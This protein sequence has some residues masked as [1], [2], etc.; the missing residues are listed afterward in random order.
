M[1][2][3]SHFHRQPA[4]IALWR[5]LFGPLLRWL[6]SGR[7]RV[8]LSLGA[9]V[10][11]FSNPL[12]EFHRAR[13]WLEFAPDTVGKILAIAT[14]ILLVLACYHVAR[15]FAALPP[16][17]RR[18]PQLC[19]HACFWLWMIMAWNVTPASVTVRTVLAGC[20]LFLPL[21]LWR[22]GYLL[23]TAQRGKMAG[24]SLHDHWFY[25]WPV[26]GGGASAAPYGKGY[27]Y[28]NSCD[29]RDEEALARTQLSGI[30]LLMLALLCGVVKDLLDALVFGDDNI[31]RRVFGGLTLNIA[32]AS[33]MI[34]HPGAAPV[35]HGWVAIYSDLFRQVLVRCVKGHVIIACLRFGGFY[36]FRNTYKPLAAETILEFWNRYYYYFK[37]LLVNFFFF[38]VFTRHFKQSPRLRI[39]AAVFASA[40]FGNMY[41]H[42]IASP[43]F[44]LGDWH[45]LW[46]AFSPRLFY[47]LVLATGIYLSMLREKGRVKGGP[48]RSWPRRALAIFGVWTFFAFI[49]LWA[50]GGMPHAARFHFVLELLGCG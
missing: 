24:T 6:T 14:L 18:H 26:W 47:C 5:R 36:A 15:R 1:D 22:V 38:P 25:I 27:D 35:W 32:T 29:A 4:V 10:I 33:E 41:Y 34:K 9:L 37:E 48:P 43:E 7:R 16:W 45:G 12:R 39:A 11:A 8:L 19:L 23:M 46:E 40:F 28:L 17:V 13:K 30:K 21:L 42:V 20:A 2:I 44:S 50:K 31:F 3:L 49:H